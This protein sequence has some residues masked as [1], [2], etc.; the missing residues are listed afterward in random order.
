MQVDKEA[1]RQRT[2]IEKNKATIEQKILPRAGD[3]EKEL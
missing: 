3:C 2:K 1:E